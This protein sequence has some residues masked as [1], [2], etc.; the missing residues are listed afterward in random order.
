MQV[1]IFTRYFDE[2]RLQHTVRATYNVIQSK[3]FYID[4][5]NQDTKNRA[6]F[7]RR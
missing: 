6:R 1:F 4:F 5:S 2:I 3:N 7:Y